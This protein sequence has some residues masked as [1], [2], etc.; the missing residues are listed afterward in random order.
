VRGNEVRPRQTVAIEKDAIVAG[1]DQDRAVAN[2]G[3]AEP[4]IRMPDVNDAAADA[5]FPAVN[6][7]GSLRFGAVVGDQH[8]EFRIVLRRERPQYRIECV[9][10]IISC[11]DDGY[12]IGHD[13]TVPTK[14]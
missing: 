7:G 4:L 10:T 6:Q 12:K 9:R 11:D 8:F 14:P 13:S 2:F 5:A 3:E 1:R